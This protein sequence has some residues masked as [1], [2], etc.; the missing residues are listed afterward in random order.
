M[1]HGFEIDPP[2]NASLYH[3]TGPC[4]NIKTVVIEWTMIS[5]EVKFILLGRLEVYYFETDFDNR[6]G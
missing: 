6:L 2:L 1:D 5:M 3:G 4:S